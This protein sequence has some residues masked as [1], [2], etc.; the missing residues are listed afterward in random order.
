MARADIAAT[1]YVGHGITPV[2]APTI[3]MVSAKVDIVWG[4]PG[5]LSAVFV[6]NNESAEAAAVQLGFPVSLPTQFRHKDRLDF[7][8][9]FDGVP[10]DRAAIQQ[11]KPDEEESGWRGESL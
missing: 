10:A 9:T 8:M 1:Q 3:R 5:T 6:M 4:E 2:D 11:A 7:T